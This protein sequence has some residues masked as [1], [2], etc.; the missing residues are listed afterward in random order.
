M[1]VAKCEFCGYEDKGI[2]QL[3][4]D[5]LFVQRLWQNL[6]SIL[7]FYLWW[8]HSIVGFYLRKK[9]SYIIFINCEI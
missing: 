7:N 8:K 6:N 9:Y 1:Y 2:R 3:L 5:C 4:S